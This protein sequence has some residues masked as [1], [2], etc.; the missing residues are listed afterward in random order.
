MS[1]PDELLEQRE[2]DR[3]LAP[4]RARLEELTDLYARLE[5]AGK[6]T[7]DV[8]RAMEHEFATIRAIEGKR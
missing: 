1:Q 7:A 8:A 3:L 5:L 6:P 2:L 4:H